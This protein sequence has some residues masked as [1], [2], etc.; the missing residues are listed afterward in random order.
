MTRF[1]T[2]LTLTASI[3]FAQGQGIVPWAQ[4]NELPASMQPPVL[5]K[6]SIDQQLNA[7]V[8]L[9]LVF[10]DETGKQVRLGDYF[11]HRPVVLQLV[12]Y[13]CPMLCTLAMNG[14]LRAFRAMQFTAG[15]QFEAVMVSINPSETPALAAAKKRTYIAEYR[16]PGA[17]AGWHFLTGDEP[18][19]KAL[20]DS[21]GFHY[22]YDPA[23]KQ[24]AHATGFMVLTPQ[25]RV[26]AYQ[27]GV[28]YSARDLRLSL[29][30]ASSGRIGTPVDRILLY[31][32]HYDPSTGK[33][34]A[35]VFNIVRAAA[36]F[37]VFGLAFGIVLMARRGR[38]R[39]IEGSAT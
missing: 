35:A 22:A 34:S 37:A 23:S 17:E 19:I 15:S 38:R 12:Y 11:G 8:P 33:Y 32:F 7:Q 25:G 2:I 10:R 21:V 30:N 18:S 9:S 31:C 14:L 16:R 36:I 1:L 20:A 3:V 13:Q 26:A 39:R 24:Y 6:V 27:L 4:R 29:V 28:E 5:Q